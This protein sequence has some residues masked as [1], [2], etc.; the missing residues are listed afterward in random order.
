MDGEPA[1][2]PRGWVAEGAVRCLK[3]ERARLR[4]AE[5]A[6]DAAALAERVEAELRR[7]PS[8]VRE[9][10]SVTGAPVRMVR[11]ARMRLERAGEIEPAR[12]RRQA[13]PERPNP[14]P[15]PGALAEEELRRDPER[16]DSEISRTAGV[17]VKTV[18][19]ARKRL[20]IPTHDPRRGDGALLARIGS[21]TVREFADAAGATETSARNRLA[22]LVKAGRATRS[23]G[24]PTTGVAPYLYAPAG[25]A[26]TPAAA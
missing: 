11:D 23:R 14:G 19:R 13:R 8:N 22:A 1:P 17:G 4:A 24:R 12:R 7:D 2:L 6:G 21:A 5:E 16:S 18:S 26:T 15:G 20:G 10:A 3:C 9:V 25:E